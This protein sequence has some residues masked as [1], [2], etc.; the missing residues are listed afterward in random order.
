VKTF[1]TEGAKCAPA[2]E[3]WTWHFQGH[4]RLEMFDTGHRD[5]T[6]HT[7]IGYA[8]RPHGSRLAMFSGADYGCPAHIPIDSLKAAVH[9]LAF[10]TLQPGDTDTDYFKTHHPDQLDWTQSDEADGLRTFVY[11]FENG[12]QS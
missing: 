2:F 1:R 6:G 12:G 5:S 7:T 9:L 11:D 3:G 8:Y 4:G 10:L